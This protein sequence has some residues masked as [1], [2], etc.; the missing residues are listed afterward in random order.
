MSIINKVPH[1]YQVN[2]LAFLESSQYL[3]QGTGNGS[4]LEKTSFPDM[5]VVN[6]Y[7][8]HT[9]SVLSVAVDPSEKYIATGGADAIVCLWSTED[10]ICVRSYY[11]MEN[12]IKAISFSHDSKYMSMT[13]EDTCVYVENIQTGESLGT[14]ELQ[15]GPDESCW[16]A[17]NHILAYPTESVEHGNVQFNIELRYPKRHNYS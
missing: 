1:K 16:S 4:A 14:I 6:S 15:A 17:S 10:M 3:L 12:P 9:A 8:G 13:G 7:I 2:E 5:Q 11:N